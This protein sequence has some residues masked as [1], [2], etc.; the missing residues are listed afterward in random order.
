MIFFVKKTLLENYI[1]LLKL[2]LPAMI[3]EHFDL[4]KS[5]QNG[6]RLEL[7]FEEKNI[8][9]QEFENRQLASKGFHKEV[10]VQDFPLRGKFVYLHVKRRRWTDKESGEIVQRDWNMVS[11]GTRMTEEFASFLKEINQY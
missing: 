7:Y 1:D 8:P 11:K 9:P 2:V 10:V 4:I 5:H 6:E 3:V